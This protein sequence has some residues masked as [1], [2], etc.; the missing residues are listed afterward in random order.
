MLVDDVAVAKDA[1]DQF[2]DPAHDSA[3]IRRAT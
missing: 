1:V 3:Y 2:G